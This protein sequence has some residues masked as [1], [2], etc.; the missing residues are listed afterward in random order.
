MR[1]ETAI[2]RLEDLAEEARAR[3]DL[4]ELERLTNKIEA[5]KR[6]PERCFICTYTGSDSAEMY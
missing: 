1:V 4:K 2:E 3:K 5:Y 6:L